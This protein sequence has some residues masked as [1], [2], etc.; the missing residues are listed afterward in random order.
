MECRYWYQMHLGPIH[1]WV[2]GWC[3]GATRERAIASA[4]EDARH[5][6]HKHRNAPEIATT[7]IHLRHCS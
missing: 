7:E 3:F 6:Y 4:R 5:V 2:S 1:G